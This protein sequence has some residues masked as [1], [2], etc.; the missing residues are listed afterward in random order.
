MF[1]EKDFN[2]FLDATVY[3]RDGEKV[4]R[5]GQL[6][7]DEETGAPSWVS[8]ATGWFGLSESLVPIDQ[9]T[10]VVDGR[11]DVPFEKDVI[12]DAPRVDTDTVLDEADEERLYAHYGRSYAPVGGDVDQARYLSDEESRYRDEQADFE[13]VDESH[14]DDRLAYGDQRSDRTD[15]GVPDYRGDLTRD[16]DLNVGDDDL[17]SLERDRQVAENVRADGVLAPGGVDDSYD[18]GQV[19]DGL[20]DDHR[21][22]GWTEGRDGRVSDTDN[23]SPG[24]E[25][26]NPGDVHD[27]RVDADNV[28]V[29]YRGDAGDY[30]REHIGDDRPLDER[31]GLEESIDERRRRLRRYNRPAL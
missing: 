13:R 3:D 24:H 21:P 14:V 17:R 30:G 27:A 4:G 18:N 12:K 26:R 19:G 16:R 1:D 5:V 29:E 11:I 25:M 20:V 10:T 22:D 2:S 9:T 28:D 6:F 31:V 23:W 7:L 15:V 8:V